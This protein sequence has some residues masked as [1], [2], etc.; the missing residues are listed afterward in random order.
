MTT[1]VKVNCLSRDGSAL[2][3][4]S[5]VMGDRPGPTAFAAHEITMRRNDVAIFHNNVYVRHEWYLDTA[6]HAEILM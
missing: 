2:I 3:K 5:N 6:W 1:T 4:P